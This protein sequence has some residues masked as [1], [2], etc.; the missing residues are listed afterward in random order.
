[1]NHR[2]PCANE[3]A[4]AAHMRVE[5]ADYIAGVKLERAETDFREEMMRH[6][7]CTVL[8]GSTRSQIEWIDFLQEIDEGGL[9]ER[10]GTDCLSLFEKFCKAWAPNRLAL[11]E[12]MS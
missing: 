2:L 8:I 7:C 10:L 1:M 4:F 3:S 5:D 12:E 9:W 6:G 11:T